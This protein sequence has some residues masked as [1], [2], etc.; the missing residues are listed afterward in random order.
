[1]AYMGFFYENVKLL[2]QRSCWCLSTIMVHVDVRCAL[3]NC[4]TVVIDFG[5]NLNL[6]L[7]LLG[8]V[9][10]CTHTLTLRLRFYFYAELGILGLDTSRAGSGARLVYASAASPRPR[11]RMTARFPAI[12]VAWLPPGV[13]P[14]RSSLSARRLER[15]EVKGW[16]ESRNVAMTK[17]EIL[18]G[19]TFQDS[20][21][22]STLYLSILV[23]SG[24]VLNCSFG[25]L[26]D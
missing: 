5:F 18:R 26:G 9:W 21:Q 4:A 14:P 25:S 10:V 13:V 8:P 20:A 15:L 23:Q 19:T 17:S 24:V 7:D 11:A 2:S 6:H 16:T 22:P 1:M 12:L 3:L